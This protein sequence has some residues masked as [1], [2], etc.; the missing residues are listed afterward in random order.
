MRTW[1]RQR[2]SPQWK[3]HARLVLVST[4]RRRE[5]FHKKRQKKVKMGRDV[6]G[7][8]KLDAARGRAL[9]G[10]RLQSVSRFSLPTMEL[11]VW[12][13]NPQAPSGDQIADPPLSHTRMR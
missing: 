11:T 7:L 4:N 10:I 13:P 5:F 1:S 2:G 6:K 12:T 8:V 3:L 9:Q